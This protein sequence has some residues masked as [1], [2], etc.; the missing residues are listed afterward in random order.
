MQLVIGS[1]ILFLVFLTTFIFG[2][3]M[4]PVRKWLLG[5]GKEEMDKQ[6][7]LQELR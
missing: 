2:S 1:T 4:Q 6:F 3:L 5:N 7:D